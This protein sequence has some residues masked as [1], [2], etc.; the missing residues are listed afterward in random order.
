MASTTDQLYGEQGKETVARAAFSGSGRVHSPSERMAQDLRRRREAQEQPSHIVAD[1]EIK[2]VSSSQVAG[3]IEKTIGGKWVD[4]KDSSGAIVGRKKERISGSVEETRFKDASKAAEFVQEFLKNN[5][6]NVLTRRDRVTPVY[7]A[8]D[9][10]TGRET[11][12]FPD[13]FIEA[14]RK[15]T[16]AAVEVIWPDAKK[17]MSGMSDQAKEKMMDR[18]LSDP[19]FAKHVQAKLQ[20]VVESTQE[21]KALPQELIDRVSSAKLDHDTKA[22]EVEWTEA[23]LEAKKEEF[24]KEF[25]DKGSGS[26]GREYDAMPSMASL[27]ADLVS[28][29]DDVRKK[30]RELADLNRQYATADRAKNAAEVARIS[31]LI[32][33]KEGEIDDAKD[34][35]K[36]IEHKIARRKEIEDR[37]AA[38]ETSVRELERSLA[39]KQIERD[40]AQN[41]YYLTL[42]SKNEAEEDLAR[43]EKSFVSKLNNVTTEAVR[44]Y[45]K[46]EI[47]NYEQTRDTIITEHGDD[48]LVKGLQDRWNKKGKRNEFNKDTINSDYKLFI[49]QG[50]NA[51]VRA[52]LREGGM[53]DAEIDAKLAS[54]P[55]FKKRAESEVIERLLTR[56]LQ[57][58]KISEGEARRIVDM[59]GSEDVITTALE[60]R[61]KYDGTY[62]ELK[63]KGLL[64]G[65][66]M[67]KLRALPHNRIVQILM[68][69]FGLG[70]LL[71]VDALGGFG[72]ATAAGAK[73]ATG[74]GYAAHIGGVA[75]DKAAP[76]VGDALDKA[77]AAVSYAGDK[78]GDALSYAGDKLSAGADA[79]D[80]YR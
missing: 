65:E 64:G 57:T 80:K 29:D 52:T 70:G 1:L 60:N 68:L 54:Y 15:K 41:T 34:R 51:I 30:M 31:P 58:G 63:K 75:A 19:A 3:A 62:E 50:P 18:M 43:G 11:P 39:K 17:A 2:P 79:A 69:I 24:K 35:K 53:S 74:A 42:A 28:H 25:T 22:K 14:Y 73:I 32:G 40:Q 77:G 44:E 76:F 72:V 7:K 71:A 10:V 26:M 5:Y 48:A 16:L 8:K 36:E 66:F 47:G 61:A 4:V 33:T 6:A 49:N 67:R 46:G 78:G 12:V 55:D 13:Q 20:E 37:R 56:R 59:P 23:D 9:P 45:L 27:E 38:L 21:G